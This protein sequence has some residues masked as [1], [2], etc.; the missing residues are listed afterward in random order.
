[1]T[2]YMLKTENFLLVQYML[3]V[4]E[5]AIFKILFSPGGGQSCGYEQHISIIQNP[6]PRRGSMANFAFPELHP[7]VARGQEKRYILITLQ[8]KLKAEP[9]NLILLTQTKTDSH[10][11]RHSVAIPLIPPPDGEKFEGGYHIE[12]N[13]INGAARLV[14]PSKGG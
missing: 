9:E 8:A 10:G 2:V 11:R 4:V 7:K 1:M 13:P 14:H 12:R 6:R 3:N 5:K